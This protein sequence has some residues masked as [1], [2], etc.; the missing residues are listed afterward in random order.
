[1][2]KD[3]DLIVEVDPDEAQKLIE[4]AELLFEEWYV[5]Q[6]TRTERLATLV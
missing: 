6:H 2:E 4:L 3:I 5:A 1:M